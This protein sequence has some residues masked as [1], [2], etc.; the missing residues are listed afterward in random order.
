MDSGKVLVSGLLLHA[1]K[2]RVLIHD[3]KGAAVWS[4]EKRALVPHQSK[5]QVA[6][7]TLETPATTDKM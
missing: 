4:F 6:V 1:T 2:N 7:A 5:E 3:G